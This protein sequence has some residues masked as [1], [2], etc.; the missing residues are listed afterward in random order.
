[1]QLTQGKAT[2]AT[3]SP[4]LQGAAQGHT[5]CSSHRLLLLENKI[6]IE[7]PALAVLVASCLVTGGCQKTPNLFVLQLD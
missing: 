3:R 4:Q 7:I 2:R 1:M 6:Y 5:T